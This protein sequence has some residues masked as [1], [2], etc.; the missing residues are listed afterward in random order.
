MKTSPAL[1]ITLT[2]VT[3][4]ILSL[5]VPQIHAEGCGGCCGNKASCPSPT[6]S[7]SP[8]PAK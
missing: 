6:P 1:R 8:T 3:L 7:P 2:V 5:A 4:G